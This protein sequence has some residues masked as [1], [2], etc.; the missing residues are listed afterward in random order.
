MVKRLIQL[1]LVCLSFLPAVA[2]VQPDWDA[3]RSEIEAIRIQ[4]DLPSIG[5][6]LAVADRIAVADAVGLANVDEGEEANADTPY[7]LASI[8]KTY[9]AT[10]LLQLVE[11]GSLSLD[12]PVN[13]HL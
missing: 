12:D 9:A 5:Y 13:D 2:H 6:S 10:A 3:V 4:H 8:S 7:M 11:S 1:V